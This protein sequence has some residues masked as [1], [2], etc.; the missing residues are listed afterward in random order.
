MR[1]FIRPGFTDMRKAINGLSVK[2]QEEMKVDPFQRAFLSF[3]TGLEKY[4]KSYAG[5]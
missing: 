1:R 4:L 3:A 2:V 5:K